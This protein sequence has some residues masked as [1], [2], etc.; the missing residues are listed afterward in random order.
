MKN[1]E[2]RHLNPTTPMMEDSRTLRQLRRELDKYDC[3][4]C[5]DTED[6]NRIEEENV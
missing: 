2:Q 1:I 3:Y 4:N 6:V 5:N